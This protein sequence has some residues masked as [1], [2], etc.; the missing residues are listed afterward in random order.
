MESRPVTPIPAPVVMEPRPVAPVLEPVMVESQPAA[1]AMT[2]ILIEPQTVLLHP[3]HRADF[4]GR[5]DFLPPPP[6]RRKEQPRYHPENEAAVDQA[7]AKPMSRWVRVAIILGVKL[8]L[9]LILAMLKA[10]K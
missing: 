1:P 3:V 8:F 4:S 6:P 2:P 7:P 10:A 9:L 5:P